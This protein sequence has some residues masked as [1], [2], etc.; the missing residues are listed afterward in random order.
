MFQHDIMRSLR[1]VLLACVFPLCAACVTSQSHQRALDEK[2]ATI[3]ELRDE[4]SRLKSQ[5]QELAQSRDDALGQLA[6]SSAREDRAPAAAPAP[7]ASAKSFPELDSLGVSYGVRDGNMV[8]SIPASITFAS[9]K[10]ELSAD[11]KKA[12]KKVAGTLQREYPGARLRVEGHT[13]ADP[14]KK[15]GFASN[16]ELSV[17]RAMAVLRFLVEDCGVPDE[18]CIVAGHGQY[19][20]V[21]GNA[22]D[23]EKARNRRVEIVVLRGKG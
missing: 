20:P 5:V 7:A 16:R 21:A 18:R 2:D 22:K 12:L 4:R 14:I 15:S 8:L 9:G 13:D 11:G 23:A 19:D 17:A 10:A 1:L 3:R 6:E